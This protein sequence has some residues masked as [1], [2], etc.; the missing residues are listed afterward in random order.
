MKFR[1][2]DTFFI[3]KGWLSKGMR[4]I[5]ETPDVF[6]SRE[7]NPMDVLGIGANMVKA[8]RYWLVAVG[9]TQESTSGRRIQTPTQLGEI[10]HAHDRYFEE[11]GTLWLLHYQL[12]K[13]K[14]G[15]DTEATSWWYFFN[16]FKVAEFT[17][18]DF[19]AYINK[20]LR[21]SDE[22]DKPV[23]TIE[24]DF[25]CII[26]TYV[27]RI[28]SSPEKVRPESNI[29]CPLGEL[30]LID[31]V[32]TEKSG[33]R[34]KI[35]RKSAPK[36]D[37]L[38]PLILLAVIIDQAAGEKEVRISAIQND[39][40]NAGKAFNLDIISLTALLYKIELL[41]HI[42]VVRTAGLDVIQIKSNWSFLDCVAKY[43]RAIN[44]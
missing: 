22:G 35:Y 28:K 19:L 17:R 20:Y 37:T 13:A 4:N 9:L 7:N 10:I 41:G 34:L 12:V 25:N 16:E 21:N 42:K 32:G 18:D 44:G 2:H 23:R 14:D 29:D 8:M 43:Y 11:M 36:K 31:I 24:D 39:N 38:H 27:P 15:R 26:N 5:L 30:G 1:A 33:S 3:R 40:G 6:V